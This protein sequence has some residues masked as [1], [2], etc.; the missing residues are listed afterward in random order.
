MENKEK[1]VRKI[2]NKVRRKYGMKIPVDFE[3][4]F[5]KKGI[6]YIEEFLR[7]NGD[8]YSDL[9]N[10]KL[11]IVVNSDI[12]YLSRK[13]FT[14][15][16][17]LGHIFIGWHDDVT[18]CQT[19]NEYTLH[20]MLDIQEK[21]ANVFASEMLMPTDW[22]K[23]Q[24]KQYESQGIDVLIKRLCKNAETSV[25]AAF[26]ALENAFDSGNVMIVFIGESSFGK[27][28][29]A[30]KTMEVYFREMDF[31][32]TCIEL[33]MFQMQYNIGSYIIDYFKFCTCPEEEK[34]LE[35]YNAN[36]RKLFKTLMELSN[37]HVLS[38]LH[39][40]KSILHAILD[41]YI[42][43]L[44]KGQRLFLRVM[45]DGIETVIPYE[46]LISEMEDF[47]IKNEYEYERERIE[48]DYEIIIVKERVYKDPEYWR[49]E[50]KNSKL[51]IKEMLSD[52]YFGEEF[53]RKRMTINGIIGAANSN[54]KIESPQQM[55]D[56]LYKKM[57]RSELY[58]FTMH[59]YYEKFLSIK[60]Y[61]LFQKYNEK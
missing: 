14:I 58:E 1:I 49:S 7:T 19:D 61:E 56:L 27:K 39:C 9:Q 57:N 22:V 24:I 40:I 20:N 4:V 11:K 21:E 59:E 28:F 31:F 13:R 25:M 42:I 5:K 17:E 33:S 48:K 2:A 15:A 36:Q 38:I 50:K 10:D 45:S 53:N 35:S 12:E 16:H 43:C 3:T 51:L 52:L 46:I 8:G 23:E 44:Y 34:I 37:N 60:S 54:R 47:C 18:I 32:E 30:E 55:Y 29:V 26:Y 6:A 41:R